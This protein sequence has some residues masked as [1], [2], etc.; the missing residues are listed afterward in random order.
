MQETNNTRNLNEEQQ[1]QE[2]TQE[3]KTE[4]TESVTTEEAK[5]NEPPAHVLSSPEP[6]PTTE[7]QPTSDP[8][9]IEEMVWLPESGTKYHCEPDCSGMEN[10]TQVTKEQAIAMGYD[11]CKRC[12]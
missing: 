8:E 5:E 1:E 12:C 10:P 11:A 6:K 7:S 3:Q 4:E 2:Q 9:P